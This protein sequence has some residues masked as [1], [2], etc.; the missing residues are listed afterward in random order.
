ME[1]RNFKINAAQ[2]NIDWTGRKI[3]GSHNGTIAIK[4]GSLVLNDGKLAGGKFI[5][6]VRSIRILDIT[7]PNTNAQ[8]AG[9]L[10][11]DDFFSS[12]QHPE[13]LLEID[14]AVKTGS[15]R[16]TVMGDLTIKGIT[17][18]ITF[19]TT[20]KLDG[21]TLTAS[22]KMAVDRTKYN[23]K[24]RSGNFFQNLGDT[25]IYNDFDLEVSLVAEAI[26]EHYEEDKHAIE[27]ALE[28]YY[29]KGI[30]EG[31]PGLL[32]K[33]YNQGTLLFGDVKGQ[34]YSKTLTEYLDGVKNRQSPKDSG[35]PFKG[36]IESIKLINSI[37]V[38]EVN[39]KMYDH[40]YHEFLS[41][42]KLDGKWVLVNKM[43]SD[44]NA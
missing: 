26:P 29:F 34:P 13:A 15:D 12:E 25:L 28:N 23:M 18:P 40:N 10:A 17:Q 41:F 3:T 20:L 22:A 37:A 9:H 38:A 6:D 39:V 35:K 1:T 21:D 33:V 14:S 8:F 44:V 43:L 24:F 36:E 4:E 5:V 42:H 27:D 31:D 19:E 32:N 16:Y 30:Y 2:S 7:D 11:S